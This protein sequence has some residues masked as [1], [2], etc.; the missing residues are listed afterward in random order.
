[1]MD[2]GRKLAALHSQDGLHSHYVCVWGCG[3]NRISHESMSTHS[4]FTGIQPEYSQPLV[5]ETKN[6][7]GA[8]IQQKITGTAGEEK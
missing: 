8:L 4:V 2:C 6:I 3:C 1:M 5:L 7:F